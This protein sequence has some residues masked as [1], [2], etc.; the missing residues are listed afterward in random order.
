MNRQVLVR[1]SV[2]RDSGRQQLLACCL[3]EVIDRPATASRCEDGP[4]NLL[5]GRLNAAATGVGG[6]V[7]PWPN[8]APIHAAAGR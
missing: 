4:G 5:F 1:A 3:S 8:H 6:D 7:L 2:V